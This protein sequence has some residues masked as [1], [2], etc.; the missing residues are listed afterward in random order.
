MSEMNQH[1]EDLEFTR[2]TR[3]KVINS[4]MKGGVP[5]D[6]KELSLLLQV[7]ADSDRSA[8]SR[9]KIASDEGIS[10][11]QAMAQAVI[12]QLFQDSRSKSMGMVDVVDVVAKELPEL[13]DHLTTISITPGELDEGLPNED[14]D[15][16]VKR[17]GIDQ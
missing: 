14:F 1:D 17:M 3:K 11:K 10:S 6:V 8:L 16:F 4:L 12:A 7:M 2:S 13:P 5:N 15:G 9:K